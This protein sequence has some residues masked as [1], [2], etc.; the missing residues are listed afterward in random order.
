MEALELSFGQTY[1]GTAA[2]KREKA[3]ILSVCDV[4]RNIYSPQDRE[5]MIRFLS[6]LDIQ[7]W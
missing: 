7:I 6:C 1:I 2:Q 4:L 5:N 3:N